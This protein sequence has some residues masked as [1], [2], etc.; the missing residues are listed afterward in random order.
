VVIGS[1]II[2]ELENTPRERAVV[3]VREFTSMIRKALDDKAA[4][5]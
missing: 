1:R 2:Q 4:H 5:E 3:A